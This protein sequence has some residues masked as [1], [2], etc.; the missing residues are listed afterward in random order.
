MRYQSLIWLVGNCAQRQKIS[1]QR[2]SRKSVAPRPPS[3][4]GLEDSGRTIR[5]WDVDGSDRLEL[6][7]FRSHFLDNLVNHV[8]RKSINGLLV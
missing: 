3:H 4:N 5:F 8:Q 7:L 6:E 2:F 1:C